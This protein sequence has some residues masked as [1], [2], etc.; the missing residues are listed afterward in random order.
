MLL[1]ELIINLLDLP[2]YDKGFKYAHP[3]LTEKIFFNKEHKVF[4]GVSAFIEQRKSFMEYRMDRINNFPTLINFVEKASRMKVFLLGEELGLLS[5]DHNKNS[6]LFWYVFTMGEFSSLE[7]FSGTSLEEFYKKL[8]FYGE[9]P[10]VLPVK[11]QRIKVYKGISKDGFHNGSGD[12]SWSLSRN[13]ARFFS[14]RCSV[15]SY[16]IEGYVEKEDVL[17]YTNRRSEEELIILPGKVKEVSILE[18]TKGNRRSAIF[19]FIQNIHYPMDL[20][21]MKEKC[22]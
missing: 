17:H 16:V 14:E 12:V 3:L 18:R 6:D 20:S 2:P 8:K 4:E 19:E 11:D 7:E 22:C 9:G 10:E 1:K 13:V 5:E 21:E 15:D